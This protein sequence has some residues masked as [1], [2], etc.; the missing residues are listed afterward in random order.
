MEE[1]SLVEPG[2]WR[3]LPFKPILFDVR[4]LPCPKC[5]KC[6]QCAPAGLWIGDLS[7]LDKLDDLGVTHV[8]V[9]SSIRVSGA[10][11]LEV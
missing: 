4:K 5:P 3:I 8:L 6:P 1:P 2:E 10:G 7:S 9:R 11:A